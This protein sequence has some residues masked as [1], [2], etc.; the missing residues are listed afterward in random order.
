MLCST[1]DSENREGR[2]FCSECGAPLE[3]PCPQCGFENRA[4]EKFCGGCGSPLAAGLEAEP[5]PPPE[6]TRSAERRQLT[7]MFCDLVGSTALS[8]LYDPEELRDVIGAFQ[9][10]CAEAIARFDGFIARYMGDGLL[11]YFGYPTAHED[12]AERAVRAGLAIV[13]GVAALRPA[14][15][16]ALAVRVG[17][18]TGLVVA[19]DIIGEGASEERAVLGETPNLAARLQ[20]L[21]APNAVVV[22]ASTFRLIEHLFV[23]DDLGLHQ[24]KGLSEPVPVYRVNGA[25]EAPS[26]FEATA[27]AALTPLVGRDEEMALLLNRWNRAKDGEGQVVLLSAEAGLGKSRITRA[28]R[29]SLEDEPHYQILCFCSPY[30]QNSALHPVIE[31]LKRRLRFAKGDTAERQIER[32]EAELADLDLPVAEYAPVIANLLS[33]PVGKRYPLAEFSPEQ[34]KLKS[35]AVLG[36][37]VAATSRRSPILMIF[38]DLHWV[39]PSTLGCLGL[40]VERVS[41]LPVVLVMSSRPE[42]EPPW[43]RRGHVTELGLS[44]LSRSESQAILCRQTGGKPLPDSV[45]AEIVAKTDGVPLFVEE[46]TKTVIE[47]DLLRDTGESYELAGPLPP[48]AIPTSLQDSLMARLDHLAP[49]KE[50]AQFAATL[51]RRFSH[52]ILTGTS[53]FPPGFLG[54]AMDRLLDA[55]LVYRNGMPPDAV[56]EFKHALVQDAAYQSLLKSRRRQFHARIAEA[57]STGVGGLAEDEP[58]LLGHH[59]TEAGLPER[60][61]PYWLEAG[62][63]AIARF[64]NHEAIAHLTRGL[65]VLSE[66]PDGESRMRAELAMNFGLATAMRV[67]DRLDEAFAALDAAERVAAAHDLDVDLSRIHHLRGNLYFPLGRIEGCHQQH[68]L[69]LKHAR[70]AKSTVDE[71]RALGGLGDAAYAHGHMRTANGYFRDCVDLCQKNGFDDIGVANHSMIGFTS[72]YLLEL[73]TAFKEGLACVDMARDIGHKR[74]ELLGQTIVHNAL[75]EMGRYAD[76]QPHL[77][78]AR[79]LENLIGARRFEAETLLFEAKALAVEGAPD[80]AQAAL[81]KA[82]TICRET[83][84][85]FMGPWVMA[86]LAK[87]ANRAEARNRLLD[88]A[89]RVLEDGAVGHSHLWFYRDAMEACFAAGDIERLERYAEGLAAYTRD[90]PLPW[91]DFFVCRGR[92]LAAFA[93]GRRDADLM[94]E[95]E[96]LRRRATD[97][98]LV[99]T[100]PILDSMLSSFSA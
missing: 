93:R 18:A 70:A 39:D 41:S 31:Q 87:H 88:E 9:S 90:E 46:L 36:D 80:K 35:I 16:A 52:E 23:F 8:Q 59:F 53:P 100:L 12:D 98:G 63:R 73:N 29:D 89:E 68:E 84:I 5:K 15:E 3:A 27:A 2:R 69:A 45:M 72:Q 71:A 97:A 51:G 64:A 79:D 33:V 42:F 6:E 48:L 81:R 28:L 10:A 32:I 94:G 86:E 62:E 49:V 1:C 30:F 67:I 66:L 38:E 13:D 61:V 50:V 83:G 19:G 21:A 25:T 7:V 95:F 92:A 14:G 58:A 55:G 40:L 34:M 17:I 37:V 78:R 75:C 77:D 54:D 65:N 60:A 24:V 57:L 26:R 43:G 44:R 82:L 91:A 20:G 22:G 99:A 4:G 76:A 11:V 47:S 85:S 56:Y 96:R 74:A